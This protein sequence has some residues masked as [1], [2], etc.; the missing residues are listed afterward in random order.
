MNFNEAT[1]LARALVTK[2]QKIYF[3]NEAMAA[4]Q[5]A[6]EFKMTNSISEGRVVLAV[7]IVAFR[8]NQ[9]VQNKYAVNLDVHG[10]KQIS[11]LS[12]LMHEEP[13]SETPTPVCDVVYLCD[14][15]LQKRR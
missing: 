3:T 9:W 10:L 12:E 7:C 14:Y 13:L 4:S 11:D 15:R 1:N 6:L 5:M 2:S 8:D